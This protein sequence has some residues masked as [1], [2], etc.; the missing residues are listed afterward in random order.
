MKHNNIKLILS[1]LLLATVLFGCNSE[2]SPFSGNDTIISLFR[3]EK[4][5]VV[6]NA[7]IEASSVVVAVP[8]S[9][10]LGGAVATVIISENAAISPDPATIDNWDEAHTFTV[11]SYNGA[12]KK[13]DY[14]VTRSP[15]VEAGNITLLTQA[16][17]DALAELNLNEIYGTLTVGSSSGADSVYSLEPLST[18]RI[19]KGGVRI[20]STYAGKD[21]DGLN[22]LEETGA[23]VIEQNRKLETISLPKLARIVSEF[24]VN[25]SKVKVLDFPALKSI[26]KKT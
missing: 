3:L 21:L 7:A 1:S 26:D 5:G 17:V 19:I 22:N 2:D 14:S 23:F 9:M 16:D 12:A 11:T 24:R 13:Y 20:H 6:I 18:L 4:G 8:E 15:I 25:Q 10:S